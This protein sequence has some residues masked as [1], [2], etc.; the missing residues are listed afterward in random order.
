MVAIAILPPSWALPEAPGNVVQLRLEVL[1]RLVRGDPNLVLSLTGG[2]A[3]HVAL[4][5]TIAG[6]FG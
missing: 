3:V 1:H 4:A 2:T 5:T 6:G